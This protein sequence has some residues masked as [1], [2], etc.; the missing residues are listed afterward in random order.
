MG[1]TWQQMEE[2]LI[3]KTIAAFEHNNF[4]DEGFVLITTDGQRL[5]VGWSGCEGGAE[6]NNAMIYL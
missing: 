4:S 6:L 2:A 1:Y 3:G 5:E